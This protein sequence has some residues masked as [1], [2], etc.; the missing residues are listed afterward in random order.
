MEKEYLDLLLDKSYS[1]N[2]SI[3][4]L[5][6]T[7]ITISKAGVESRLKNWLHYLK[8]YNITYNVKSDEEIQYLRDFF[9]T[10]CGSYYGFKFWDYTDANVNFKNL[11]TKYLS[12][13]YLRLY[14][15]FNFNE[16][17]R[18]V[19]CWLEDGLKISDFTNS[20]KIL[21]IDENEGKIYLNETEI[22]EVSFNKVE[23]SFNY[24]TELSNNFKQFLAF[25]KILY[26]K[27]STEK[28]DFEVEL[29]ILKIDESER[30]I[31]F[32]DFDGKMEKFEENQ[33][34]TIRSYFLSKNEI[35]EIK[36]IDK[37]LEIYH[38]VR[39]EDDSFTI[40]VDDYNINTTQVNLVELR[41]L[42]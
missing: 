6:N 10:T 34:F 25:G 36:L 28:K 16:E 42:D 41:I 17:M 2:C 7:T 35:P 22:I 29:D 27:V 40:N 21:K 14:K 9:N 13:N 23:N 12:R 3:T 30:K 24:N 38:I 31:Y 4:N 11:K 1:Y 19:D 15:K 18:K 20:D 26:V 8:K 33:N 5:Y 39:F 32:I 37:D